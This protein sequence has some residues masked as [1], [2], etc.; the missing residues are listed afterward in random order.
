MGCL[1]RLLAVSRWT[2][3]IALALAVAIP[4]GCSAHKGGS[5]KKRAKSPQA[6]RQKRSGSKKSRTTAL[7]QPNLWKRR[8]DGRA[9]LDPRSAQLTAS[10]AATVAA[11]DAAG[12][13]TWI[14][15]TACAPHVY[16][17]PADQPAVRVS[18]LN[19]QR[20]GRRSLQA[21][22]SAVPI[23][24]DATGSS[25][26]DRSLVIEQPA[27]NRMWEL[28]HA[29]QDASGWRADWGGATRHL[30]DD[31]G[32]FGTDDWPGAQTYW[33]ASASSLTL[34]G[35][36]LTP[37]E[38]QTGQIDHALALSVP[39]SAAGVWSAPAQ[40]TDGVSS[41]PDALPYG[42]RLRLDPSVDVDSLPIPEVTKALARAAQRYGVIVREQT[43]YNVQFSAEA[44]PADDPGVYRRIFSGAA[45]LNGFA[46]PVMRGFPWDKLQLLPMSLRSR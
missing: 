7:P 11:G 3:V 24:A 9:S 15:T 33:G 18:L 19:G 8:V 31:D 39:Q 32:V 13:G 16:R 20:P 26:R 29:R 10:L 46:G 4:A 36:I 27:T 28:W 35:G 37:Q 25:C 38:L 5:H 1:A 40:R 2:T 45:P 44:P 17:V 22:L 42:A 43:H 30:N 14:D 21:A 41:D 34:I 23:P 12:R 6:H